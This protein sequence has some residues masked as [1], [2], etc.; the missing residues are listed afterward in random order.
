MAANADSFVIAN[1]TTMCINNFRLPAILSYIASCPDCL[2]E[3][4][5]SK[6]GKWGAFGDCLKR[7]WL[8][9]LIPE[10]KLE[11]II[12]STS[13]FICMGPIFEPITGPIFGPKPVPIRVMISH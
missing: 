12:K 4:G 1:K 10:S 2:K 5:E 7:N 3:A 6:C 9:A 8:K 11:K 13:C